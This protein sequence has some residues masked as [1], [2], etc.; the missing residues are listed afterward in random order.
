MPE[1][2]EIER[3]FA[4]RGAS[5]L[6]SAEALRGKLLDVRAFVFDWDG[7]FNAGAKGAGAPSTFAEADSM[8]TN[9]LRY[10]HWREHAALPVTAVVTGAD[11]PSAVQFAEREHFSAVYVRL[12]DKTK[13]L[14][15]L[16]ERYRIEAPQIAYVFDDV[17]D[18]SVARRAGARFL[19]RRDASPLLLEYATKHGLCDYI[20]AAGAGAFAVREIAELVLGVLKRYEDVVT[21]RLNWDE[22]YARYFQARQ[23]GET[24]VIDSL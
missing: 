6:S 7:V 15:A 18:L 4:D 2:P 11:N 20:T 23:A 14:A 24:E 8:G 10:A 21:S 17:N 1:I 16:R 5:F 19:V 13:V 9:L 12:S 22:D 3:L